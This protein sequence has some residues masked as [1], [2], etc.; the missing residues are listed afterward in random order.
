MTDP[1]SF[2]FWS[3]WIQQESTRYIKYSGLSTSAIPSLSKVCHKID[4]WLLRRFDSLSLRNMPPFICS[5]W[6]L[7][8]FH[9]SS[10]NSP[11]FKLPT[12]WNLIYEYELI[13]IKGNDMFLK[14]DI[15]AW[16]NRALDTG[17][18]LAPWLLGLGWSSFGWSNLWSLPGGTEHSRK[19]PPEHSRSL[20]T[21]DM[22]GYYYGTIGKTK[23]KHCKTIW[24]IMNDYSM[25]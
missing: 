7:L 11:C 13:E 6:L 22:T 16:A 4:W 5:W 14:S 10:T 17:G 24:M 23:V 15:S 20:W 21:S 1:Y 25:I 8:V 2:L 18:L 19:Q 3:H 12:T 9:V